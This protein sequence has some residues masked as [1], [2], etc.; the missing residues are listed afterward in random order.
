MAVKTPIDTGAVAEL[1]EGFR[2]SLIG[3]DDEGNDDAR[4]V[5][6]GMIDRQPELIARCR[7]VADV[8]DAVTFARENDLPVA[9]RGGGHNVAGSAV[10]DDGLVVDCSEMNAVHVDPEERVARVE[11]GATWADVDRETQA[12]GLVTPGGVVSSTGV[13]G[14]TL[15]GGYGHLR[16][17]YGLTCD[18]LRSVDLV[19]ADGEF[20]TASEDRHSDLFWALRGGTGDFGVVTAFEYDLHEL[21]P[22]VMGLGVFYSLDDAPSVLR[23]VREFIRDAPD[24]ITFDAVL[25]SI[26]A[27]DPF[28]DEL[29]GMPVVLLG[30][31]YAGPVEEGE[32]AFEPLREL[33]TPVM[34]IS[35]PQPYVQLQ[36]A[37]DPFF[38]EGLR[39]YWKSLYLDELSDEAI[40]T[41]VEYATERPSPKTIIPIRPRGGAIARVDPDATA[42]AERTAPFMLSIDSTWEDP[43]HDEENVR[44]TREFWEA[45]APHASNKMYLNFAMGEEGEDVVRATFGENYE[46]LVEVKTAYDPENLFDMDPNVTPSA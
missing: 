43:A 10:C 22:E 3:R 29:Q 31:T 42:F 2:G 46:R 34:D 39:Y 1:E 19:T 5:W 44:W 30:G 16:R 38:P 33:A 40:D 4:A 26:P 18:N 8:I 6:N 35:E 45:M 24:E 28:P 14:L 37:F 21:G 9:V 15:G 13:A 12:F 25:W 36:S 11:A 27:V 32:D 23:E 20:L 7:G 17:K 41:I